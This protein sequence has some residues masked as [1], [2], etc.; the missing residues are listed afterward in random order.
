MFAP[1]YKITFPQSAWQQTQNG[2][3]RL[4]KKKKKKNYLSGSPPP[5]RHGFCRVRGNHLLPGDNG[6]PGRRGLE[7][8]RANKIERKWQALS[9]NSRYLPAYLQQV[10]RLNKHPVWYLLACG[11]ARVHVLSPA[12]CVCVCVSLFVCVSYLTLIIFKSGLFL[13]LADMLSMWWR[14]LR[15]LFFFLSW[16]SK[17]VTDGLPFSRR[18]FSCFL[19]WF[20]LAG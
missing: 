14:W 18:D 4:K 1:R 11:C 5:L 3:A 16:C 15:N 20:F 7:M 19:F 12:V 17:T 13:S 8:E 9:Q 6:R 2:L 10:C